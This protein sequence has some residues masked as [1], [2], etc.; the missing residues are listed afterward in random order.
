MQKSKKASNVKMSVLGSF[1]NLEKI[2]NYVYQFLKSDE[3][4][5]AKLPVD[6]QVKPTAVSISDEFIFVG[7][8]NGELLIYEIES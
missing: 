5:F 4:S 6:K 7:M 3:E 8:S 2:T 1:T